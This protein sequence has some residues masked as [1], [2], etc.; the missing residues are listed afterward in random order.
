MTRCAIFQNAVACKEIVMTSLRADSVGLTLIVV[1][2][3]L[4]AS[5]MAGF[6][7]KDYIGA[8]PDH[9]VVGLS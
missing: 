2:V 9:H 3:L 8:C 1:I 5:L 7:L 4:L 6:G